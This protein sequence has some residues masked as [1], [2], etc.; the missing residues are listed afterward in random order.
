MLGDV[1]TFS[2]ILA[3]V[4]AAYATFA[5]WRGI[6]LTDQRWSQSGRNALYAGTVLLST[7]VLL[8]LAAFLTHSFRLSYVS[9]HSSRALPVY[10]QVSAVW[11]GQE[12]SLLLWAFMQ[13]LLAG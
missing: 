13:M 11:A 3:A 8:L 7:A 1:G 12:G 2:L 6:R 5:T 9:Q 10:L 4:A